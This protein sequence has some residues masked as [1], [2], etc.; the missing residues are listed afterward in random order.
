MKNCYIMIIMIRITIIVK[1]F[2]MTLNSFK[3]IS[4]FKN[5]KLIAQTLS[6]I[7]DKIKVG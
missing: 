7:R 3:C 2:W 4:N 5:T 1:I 6:K